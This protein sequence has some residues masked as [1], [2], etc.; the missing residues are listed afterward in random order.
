ME[1]FPRLYGEDDLCNFPYGGEVIEKQDGIEELGEI[2]NANSRQ[3]LEDFTR[4]EV[5]DRGFS[6]VEM[7]DDSLDISL[8]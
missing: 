7:V 5:R 3:F 6:W 1:W 8:S 2:F 4:N